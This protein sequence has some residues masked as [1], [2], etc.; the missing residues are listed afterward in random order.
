MRLRN[1]ALV[2]AALALVPFASAD[3]LRLKDGSVIK[4]KILGLEP[5]KDG[6]PGEFTVETPFV[7]GANAGEPGKIKVR[8]ADVSTFS[9]DGDFLFATAG[10]TRAKGKVESTDNGVK[11]ATPDGVVSSTV[12]NIRDGWTPGSPSPDDKARAKLERRWEYTADI[13][14][15]GKTGN[16]DA[17]G[18]STG[19]S[20]KN[21]GPDDDLTF[22]AK[23]EYSKSKA[24][25]GAWNKTADNLHAGIEYNSYFARPL[26]WYVRS[27]NGYD[28]VRELSFFSTDALGLGNLL[29]D[30]N[31][32]GESQ[33]LSIRGGLSYRF[34][35]YRN[36]L[37]SNTSSPGLDLGLHHDCEFKYFTMVNNLTYTPAFQD[38]SNFIALHDSYIEMP[39]ANT[40][41]WKLRL[42][43]SNEYRSR[44]VPGNKRLDTTYY[45]K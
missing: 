29:I 26:F 7:P 3:E 6:A 35:S 8:Q 28:R 36:G 18:E 4:G 32:P 40:E 20:A 12:E 41:N 33:H 30:N 19:L 43:L 1:S 37:R 10:Q 5:G 21:K 27:D 25:G 39:L 22:Y 38:F 2:F 15:I 9:T 23:H 11:V 14:I 31:T 34:E 17:I 13:S 44:V 42:G 24:L 45:L 16:G